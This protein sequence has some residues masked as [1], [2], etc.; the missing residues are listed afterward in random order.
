MDKDHPVKAVYGMPC[1][2]NMQRDICCFTFEKS[3]VDVALQCGGRVTVGDSEAAGRVDHRIDVRFTVVATEIRQR[4]ERRE[5]KTVVGV[6]RTGD[7]Q[8]GG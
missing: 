3:R 8:E 2:A 5:P 1:S 4:G 6:V 7:S